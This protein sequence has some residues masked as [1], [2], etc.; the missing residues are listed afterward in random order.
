MPSIVSVGG[1]KEEREW[2]KIC[3]KSEAYYNTNPLATDG[4]PSAGYK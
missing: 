2:G 1:Q 3:L 4:I